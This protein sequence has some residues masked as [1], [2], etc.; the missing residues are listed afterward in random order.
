MELKTKRLL[1]LAT[2]VGA[3]LAAWPF[4]ELLLALQGYFAR[5]SV[6]ILTQGAVL[7]CLFGGAWGLFEGTAAGNRFRRITGL[8]RGI[9]WGTIA[10]AGAFYLGQSLLL[11]LE[12]GLS[13]ALG[14]GDLAAALSR[15]I[16]W[17]A[18]GVVVGL[19]DG[20]RTLAPRRLLLGFLGGLTGGALGGFTLEILSQ[21]F[22]RFLLSRGVGLLLF[23]CLLALF[24][25]LF[26]KWLSYGTLRILNG[27]LQGR[28][29]SLDQGRCRCGSRPSSEIP[30]AGN[31]IPGLAA[32]FRPRSGE[33]WVE[34]RDGEVKINMKPI[35][36]EQPLKWED[37]LQISGVK[38]IFRPVK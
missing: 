15:S 16:A 34:P 8:I 7:G 22:P 1:T 18:M 19:V 4:M 33:I 5:Q 21:I 20:L 26:Q 35:T 13:Q 31:H 12:E 17:A 6:F 24:T 38:L 28:E 32:L 3:A 10:G 36:E 37:T 2:G 30:L 23:G 14:S 11:P 9:L 29:Y 27:P 25:A